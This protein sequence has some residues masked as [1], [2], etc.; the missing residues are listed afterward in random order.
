VRSQAYFLMILNHFIQ[1]GL[2]RFRIG[3]EQIVVGRKPDAEAGHFDITIRVNEPQFFH[4]VLRAGNLGM[5]EA[6]MERD[7]EIEEG[8]LQDFL[9]ILLRNRLDQKI[10]ARPF[11]VL[12]IFLLWLGDTL[13]GKAKNVRHHYDIGDDLFE[14]FLDSTL[15]YS[16]G[17]VKNPNDDIEELQFNKHERIC[18]KLRLKEGERLLDI[19]CG[20]GG[21][22]IHA[23]KQYGIHGTGITISHNHYQRGNT[24]IAQHGLSD[25]LRIDLGDFSRISGQFDKVVSVGM[26]EHIPRRQYGLYFGK[27]ACV[28]VPQGMGLVHTVGAN[29]P[30]NVHDPFIQKYIFPGSG[31]PRL[32]EIVEQL[33][34]H[35]LAILDVENLARHYSYTARRW[36]D[37]FQQ[38]KAALDQ[39]K[40]GDTFLRM[41]EYFLCCCIAA[42][43]ASDSALY[44]VLFIKDYAAEL[45]LHRV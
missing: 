2:V 19:G 31:Q 13:R 9:T 45:P 34:I 25:R 44:Q 5:G 17:Y 16:C 29:A 32:S 36:L 23:A 3:D 4:R 11:I 38:N 15:T 20:Y 26:M 7:F 24:N 41:W 30:K 6:Y 35:R 43:T 22:L 39:S 27:I 10:R 8:T 37:R 33:E 28:L 18:Q 14:S 1:D 21:L 12:R 40:Y 42:A